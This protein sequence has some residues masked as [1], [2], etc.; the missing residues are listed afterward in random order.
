MTANKDKSLF[1]LLAEYAPP[2]EDAQTIGEV[3]YDLQNTE[4][5][6][7]LCLALWGWP[8]M[9]VKRFEYMF[10]LILKLPYS[11]KFRF[12]EKEKII[13]KKEFRELIEIFKNRNFLAHPRAP[14]LTPSQ[15]YP[16]F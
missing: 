3:L 1:D 4:Y 5:A 11:E 13:T 9:G 12:L 14:G 6:A 8:S 15:R 2:N 16:K 10:Q 7:A